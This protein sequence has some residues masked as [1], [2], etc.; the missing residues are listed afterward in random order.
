MKT[1]NKLILRWLV[2]I[3]LVVSISC[4]V[5]SC[6]TQASRV[7]ANISSEADNFKVTR[8]LVVLNAITDTVVF[9]L[10]GAFSFELEPNRIICIVETGHGE[11]K[12]HSVGINEYTIWHIEDISGAEVSK[13]KYEVNFL[14][15]RILPVTF[16]SED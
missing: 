3:I 4:T 12:K 5:A 9:E 14:P 16:K 15:E 1:M 6:E 10:I 11:Y 2:S 13:Y 8:R 7:S